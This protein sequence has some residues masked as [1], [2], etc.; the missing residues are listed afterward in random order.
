MV[1]NRDDSVRVS[2]R[3]TVQGIVGIPRLTSLTAV[4]A[5]ETDR[6]SVFV[7]QRIKSLILAGKRSRNVAEGN[8]Q[9]VAHGQEAC[10][11]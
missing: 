7:C 4:V 9:R 1:S 2:Y 6:N 11:T 3:V 10:E 5:S 8:S